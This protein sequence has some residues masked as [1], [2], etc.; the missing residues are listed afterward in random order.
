MQAPIPPPTPTQ[1]RH[2]AEP[3]QDHWGPT[4]FLRKCKSFRQG[5]DGGRAQSLPHSHCILPFTCLVQ[6]KDWAGRPGP[7]PREAS[8]W[9]TAAGSAGQP[10]RS[11]AEIIARLGAGLSHPGQESSDWEGLASGGGSC[12]RQMELVL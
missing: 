11:P 10:R 7:G 5:K 2:G 4:E 1:R 3:T 8:G 9:R 6:G 12:P